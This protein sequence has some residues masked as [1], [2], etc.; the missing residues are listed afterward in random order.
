[1][2]TIE[3]IKSYVCLCRALTI[4]QTDMSDIQYR[5]AHPGN[6]W[7]CARVRVLTHKLTRSYAD[8]L[9]KPSSKPPQTC[10]QTLKYT[11]PHK[12]PRDDDGAQARPSP[13]RAPAN[14]Y[15]GLNVFTELTRQALL[16]ATTEQQFATGRSTGGMCVRKEREI[17]WYC[18]WA[19][20]MR[21]GIFRVIQQAHHYDA[22]CSR[23]CA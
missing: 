3:Y 18:S 12:A 5:R 2:Y 7:T 8:S 20:E 15:I 9:L 17:G 10:T 1:M 14:N 19:T 13:K 16:T 23:A 21:R 11:A 6:E 4:A 22:L